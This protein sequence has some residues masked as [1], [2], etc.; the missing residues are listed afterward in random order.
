MP[1]AVAEPRAACPSNMKKYWQILRRYKISLAVSPLLVLITVLCETIQ[2]TFMADIIDNGVMTRDLGVVTRIGTYMVLVSLTGLFF[3]VL[4]VWVSSRASIGFGTDL[5]GDLFRHIQALSFFDVDRFGSASLIT[6]LTSDISRIQQIVLMSMRMLLRSPLMLLMALFFV[7]RLN[8]QLALILAGAIPLLSI[9][10]YVILRK[11]FPYFLKVQQKLDSLNEVVRENL[12]NIRVV[13]SFVRE[14]FETRK[15]EAKSEDLSATVVKASN[16]IVSI[17]PVMQLIMNLSTLVILWAGG[18]KVMS[19]QLKVGELISFVN[20]LAQVL[21]SLM[22]L[23][24]IIMSLARASASSARILEVFATRPSLANTPEGLRN[25]YKIERGEIRFNHV[26]FR[27]AGGENDVLHDVSF[28]IRPGETVAV[29]G[30][31]GSAKS[32]LVQ[33]IPR[34]YDVTA[35][36]LL[37]DEVPVKAYNLD[38]LHRR[39]G[40]VLQKNELF[41]GT[42]LDNLKWG[43]PEASEREIAEAVRAAEAAEFIE[44]F[45]DGYETWLGRGGINLSGG[46][47]QR[48]C[49]ARALLRKPK[50]LILDDSTSAV[51]SETELKI[52]K[53][54]KTLLGQT[55]VLVVTQRISTMQSADRVVVLEEGEINAVGRPA[56]LMETSAVYREIYNSQQ[57]ID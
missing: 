44:R 14:K 39:I 46:Q 4:N 57:L 51:D 43:N 52:Q 25:L 6:R 21:M 49:I 48:L 23:S 24:M 32:S 26:Y 7:I 3:S 31:T 13:K 18:Y 47:K 20:Y 55:T 37:I 15:F 30:A 28:H 22:M 2:P 1:V 33:L 41:T 35:G 42:I 10:L 16:I 50:I 12:I 36:T 38:E 27:Y 17:F 45:A 5:R 19:G 54:L 56:D 40:M 53:N 34:L 8:P 9:S 29:V 11:G